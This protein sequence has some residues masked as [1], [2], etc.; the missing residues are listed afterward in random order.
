[1]ARYSISLDIPHAKARLVNAPISTKWAV[2]ICREIRGKKLKDAIVF[3][4]RVLKHEDWIPIRRYNKKVPHRKGKKVV[5]SG[6]YMD[7][8][9][10][11][12]LKLLREVEANA[13]AKGLDPEK[14]V[15]Y[16]AA[17]HK[18]F[19]R[20]KIQPRLR[21]VVRKKATHVEVVVVEA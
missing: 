5:K 2:E 6:R 21:R 20:P 11:Y 9:V 19:R 1:M 7:K 17:A 4:E 13:V 3:L 14:L 18:G 12:I 10:K 15:I 8:A 16:H